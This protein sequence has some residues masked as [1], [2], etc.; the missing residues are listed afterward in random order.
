MSFQK[1]SYQKACPQ[2]LKSFLM[3][4][5]VLKLSILVRIPSLTYISNQRIS[6]NMIIS[7]PKEIKMHDSHQQK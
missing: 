4:T 3:I 5:W 6:Q 7:K 1:M 2:L